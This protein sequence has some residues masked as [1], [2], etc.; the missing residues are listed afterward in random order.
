MKV[1]ACRLGL[2]RS[3]ALL[4]PGEHA[5]KRSCCILASQGHYGAEPPVHQTPLGKEAESLDSRAEHC[6]IIMLT[7][8]TPKSMETGS[9]LWE[10]SI[11]WYCLCNILSATR[12]FL[13]TYWPDLVLPTHGLVHRG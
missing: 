13:G 5:A 9:G 6:S 4:D 7:G 1:E 10:A 12:S 3:L 2:A 11:S 8:I